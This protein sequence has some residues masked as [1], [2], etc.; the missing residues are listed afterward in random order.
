MRAKTINEVHNFERGNDPKSSM[1][2][3]KV[4][5]AKVILEH[6]YPKEPL[7][8]SYIIHD[9]NNIEVFYAKPERYKYEKE[10][11]EYRWFL[12][13]VE[14]DRFIYKS[15][16][17]TISIHSDKLYHDWNI[18]ERR[19]CRR[20]HEKNSICEEYALHLSKEAKDSEKRT[21]IIID[22]LNKEYGPIKGFELVKEIKPSDE[23]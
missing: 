8:F 4:A 5:E 15:H 14:L 3:G 9:I 11:S 12:K 17:D 16:S 20:P 18:N 19:F 21:Q 1:G 2:I 23:S 13:Y 7:G 10:M 6:W 22:A